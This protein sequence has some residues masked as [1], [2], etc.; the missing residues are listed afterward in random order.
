MNKKKIK[1]ISIFM[2]TGILM[3]SALIGDFSLRAANYRLSVEVPYGIDANKDSK[4]TIGF[5][6]FSN[7][8][9]SYAVYSRLFVNT[10]RVYCIDPLTNT[11]DG[12]TAT[13]SDLGTLTGANANDIRQ[14]GYI[15]AL[16]YGF[17]GDFSD[18]MDFATE[19]RIW[20]YLN[21]MNSNQYPAITNI[22]PEIQNKINEINT[23][24]NVMNRSVSFHN[25]NIVL[26]GYGKEFAHTL[27]DTNNVLSYYQNNQITG[28]H[29][30]R[31]GN[32]LTVWA[33]KGDD[34]NAQL[35]YDCFYLRNLTTTP[36]AYEGNGS[37]NI[38]F[39]GKPDPRILQVNVKM[40]LGSIELAKE[41]FETESNPQGDATFS[42]AK[43]SL[44]DNITN[45]VV[46]YFTFDRFGK[47]TVIRELPTDR[48]YTIKEIEKPIGYQLNEEATIVDFSKLSA[49]A[50][51]KFFSTIVKDQVIM[52]DFDLEKIIT[53]GEESE[54]VKK[55]EGAEFLCVLKKYVD[56][57]GSVEAAYDHRK[58]YSQREYDKLITDENGYAKSR[59]LAFG[60]YVVKQV[61]GSVDTDLLNT[62]F[63]FTVSNEKQETIRYIIN[64]RPFT[65]FLKIV[66]RDSE[67]GKIISVAPATFKIFDVNNNSY[68]TQ[69]LGNQKIETFTTDES[70]TV[71]L[72]L[73]LK[74]GKYRLEEI[75]IQGNYT[76]ND[77]PVEFTITNTYAHQV[78]EEGDPITIV[79]MKDKAVKG[80]VE[81]FK[82]GE[83][84]KDYDKQNKE[85]IY[86]KQ[87]L[88]NTTFHIFAEKDILD[89]AD[90]SIK[91]Y[92]DDFVGEIVTN[93]KGIASLD[94]LYLGDYYAME[95]ETNKGFVL[96]DKKYSFSLVYENET[97]A[98]VT[99]DFKVENKRQKLE[100]A[101][102]KQDKK[103]GSPLSDVIFGLYNTED[104][105]NVDGK[106]IVEANTLLEISKSDI[107]GFANFTKDFPIAK[108]EI[109]EIQSQIG[110][111]LSN[112]VYPLEIDDSNQKN[113]IIK[114]VRVIENEKL[115]IHIELLK[116][117]EN[118]PYYTDEMKEA[119][120]DIRFGIFTRNRILDYK[121]DIEFE[122]NTLVCESGIDEY[123]RFEESPKLRTGD[124]YIKEISTN[125]HYLINDTE[126]DFT[127]ALNVEQKKYSIIINDGNKIENKLKRGD[128]VLL[129]LD[130][131]TKKP[132]KQVEFT[133]FDKFNNEITKAITDEKG[134]AR[135]DD[136]P[137]GEY[138]IKETKTLASYELLKDKIE[139][140]IDEN[141]KEYT[142]LVTNQQVKIIETGDHTRETLYLALALLAGIAILVNRKIRNKRK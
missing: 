110:Y 79:E 24:L 32:Q 7:V 94:N 78:D 42:N 99:E 85:F 18:E 72:P 109:R 88:S 28:L 129:K 80:K 100:I 26:K 71:T 29:S 52:G 36:I 137:V 61:K 35:R 112:D 90:H 2:I 20:Q 44:T 91:F 17:N 22:H 98:L 56:K 114:V 127:L 130:E 107:E 69:K 59:K 53:S 97:V 135:F 46:G 40:E 64:N 9:E 14:L 63:E 50:N 115:T 3:L 54:I 117:L 12:S 111:L 126:Y 134:Y 132:L 105:L 10:Q 70:G 123:G 133:L 49:S 66:K 120:K 30:L 67:S 108:Y 125:N 131:E 136:V 83:V 119:Y 5:D 68:L 96:S 106:V 116:D 1:S 73:V 75:H 25:T 37:Q 47:S 33:E 21:V 19:I 103:D 104:I 142:F 138:Y 38:A 113:E 13:I 60:K 81:I 62:A 95:V 101:V 89:P 51:E 124:Y 122:K 31:E 43:Y 45:K 15:S 102:S 16:G 140:T 41:D 77:N 76:I 23:R 65:S 82:E 39:L 84:L 86:E 27:T 92:K 48:T 11:V 8:G 4:W 118:H 58:E 34:L 6:R 128:I 87:G 74:A 121:G 57:Y 55:E 93:E 139:I 141:N